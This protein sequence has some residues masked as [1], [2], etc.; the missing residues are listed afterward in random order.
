[1]EDIVRGD[2]PASPHGGSSVTEA[3][4]VRDVLIVEDGEVLDEIIDIEIFIKE[5]RPIHP[6]AKGYLVRI[7]K[8]KYLFEK[9]EVTGEQILLKAGK[10][11]PNKYV[12][13]QILK[14]GALEK[15]ELDQV[16]DLARHGVEKFKTMLR[17]A[18]DG[19]D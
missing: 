8:Q 18:Q 14:E 3:I 4:V 13:R 15:I 2:S 10:N 6:R 1:M 17:T 5:G 19:T 11:P 12:L 16:V 9:P 7:D